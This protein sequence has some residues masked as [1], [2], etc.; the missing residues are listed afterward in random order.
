MTSWPSPG[1]VDHLLHQ[2]LADALH[3]AAMH[4]AGEQQRIER[5]AEIVDDDVVDD[6]D[7]AGGGIDLDLRE[8]G[9]VR[10]G[11][12]G[13]GEGRARV[14]LRRID[15]GRLARSA[16]LIERS[17]PAMRIVP[18]LISRSP[19]LVSSASAAISF[20]L[21]AELARRALDADAAGRNR[22]RAAGAEPGRDLVGVAL[23]DVDALRRQA[24]LLG[25][26]LRI[27]G[28]VALPAR[29]R[30]DQDRDVAIGIEPHIGGL[31]AHGAADL[32][33]ARQADAAHQALL[34]GGLGALGKL[35]PVRRSPS[36]A[37][38]AR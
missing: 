9:A 24:E 3:R 27:G 29:L 13:A 10:I 31:L 36:R 2:R 19:A 8:M 37:S 12:V 25:D 18:S 28:L 22:G 33:I 14:E 30:A 17:V 20:S 21:L 16:K 35:L 32:D 4:L 34:L 1:A 11:A 26:D 15:A 38:Y 6:L 7:D 23:V 5:H